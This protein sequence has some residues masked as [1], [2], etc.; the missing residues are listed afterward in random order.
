MLE[1]ETTDLAFTISLKR[2]TQNLQVSTK[3]PADYPIYRVK[4][5]HSADI[6]KL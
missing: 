3:S 6:S 5:G 4:S 1:A 2:N